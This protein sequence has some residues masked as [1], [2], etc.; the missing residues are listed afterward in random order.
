[1]G[2]RRSERGFIVK[3]ARFYV[4]LLLL[5]SIF[6]VFSLKARVLKLT[7]KDV[8]LRRPV[9]VWL[10][11]R[12]CC[13]HKTLLLFMYVCVCVYLEYQIFHLTPIVLAL[14]SNVLVSV[15]VCGLGANVCMCVCVHTYTQRVIAIS[16]QFYIFILDRSFQR[17]YFRS[18]KVYSMYICIGIHTY[19]RDQ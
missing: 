8:G 18:Y 17:R 1:M 4:L 7:L 5:R 14:V 12:C 10:C 15:C 13:L 11:A 2:G 9:L 16:M 19:I 3:A 6:A